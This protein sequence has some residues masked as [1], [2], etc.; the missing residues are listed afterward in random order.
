MTVLSAS[1]LTVWVIGD[2]EAGTTF[3]VYSPGL[4]SSP[5]AGA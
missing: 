4:S 2:P 5:W 1:I 3:T